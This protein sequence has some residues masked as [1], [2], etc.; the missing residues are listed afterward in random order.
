M[1]PWWIAGVSDVME[2]RVLECRESHAGVPPIPLMESVA[3]YEAIDL[4]G[5]S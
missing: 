4:F 5:R 1:S 3:R 2:A